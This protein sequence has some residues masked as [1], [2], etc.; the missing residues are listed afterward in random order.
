MRWG[1]FEELNPR[2]FRDI[3]RRR[4]IAYLPFG[5]YEWHGEALPFGTDTFRSRYVLAEVARKLGG[6]VLP[7]VWGTDLRRRKHG[8]T[9]WGMELFADADLDGNACMFRHSTFR[10]VVQDMLQSCEHLGFRL[11][12][13][14]TSHAA[15]E[16][17]GV[18]AS[19]A[20]QSEAGNSLRVHNID[21]WSVYHAP[22]GCGG[23]GGPGEAAETR[24]TSP[25]LVELDRFAADSRDQTTGLQ[26]ERV[27][28]AT[29]AV[30]RKMLDGQITGIIEQLKPI[31]AELDLG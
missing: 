2:K 28:L 21:I 22:E 26:P 27:K 1:F 14:Y 10:R 8:Q 24:I 4:P 16:Q 15:R 3:M 5:A 12:V 30:G 17:I 6:V 11:A 25:D 7:P 9:F 13:L 18:L 29:E 23:H 31:L 20:G 19:C